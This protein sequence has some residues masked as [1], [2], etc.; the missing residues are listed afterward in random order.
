MRK[1]RCM[2]AVMAMAIGTGVAYAGEG[3]SEKDYRPYPHMFFGLNGGAQVSFTHYDFSKLITPSYGVSFGAYFNPVIGARLHVSGYENKGGIKSLNETY[4][5]NTVTGSADLLLNVTNMFRSDK[6][7]VFNL[8]LLG[9]VGLAGAWDNDD[10]HALAAKA[11]ENYPMAWQDRRL[12]H[13]VRLGMQLDF[14]IAKHFGLN[15]E[16]AANNRADRINSKTTDRNDWA[17]TASLGLIFKFGQK[18]TEKMAEEPVPVAEEW[19]TRTDTVW[20]DDITYRD[21][22][23]KV[24][25]E[26]NIYYKIRLSEP[27]PASKIQKIADFV[28]AHKNCSVQVTAYADKATGTPELN[29]QYSKE[30][31]EK[32]VA[33]L[34]KAGVSRSVITSEYKGDTVQPFAENDKNRVAIVKVTGEGVKKEQV[35]TKKYRLEETRYRVK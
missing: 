14:N 27:D 21:V 32:V 29:M 4:D 34:V 33:A 15:L 30:R 8:I 35:K 6:D 28:K 12:S 22:P 26:D 13:N 7:R 17:A 20:Y 31:A 24:T 19:A 25:Y 10:F 1:I 9:G 5:F 11:A 3:N 2:L 23:E 16:L 18:K